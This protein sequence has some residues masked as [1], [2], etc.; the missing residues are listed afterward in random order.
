MEKMPM[1]KPASLMIAIGL[2]HGEG[3]QD[4]DGLDR[5]HDGNGGKDIVEEAVCSIAERLVRDGAPAIR[6]VRL[7][8]RAYEDMAQAALKKDHHALADAAADAC[9]A[10][11]GLIED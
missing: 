1:P 3:A 4:E 9:D 6:Q 8:A 11:R 7:V 2:P 5:E 10:L